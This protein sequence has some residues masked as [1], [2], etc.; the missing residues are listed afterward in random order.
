MGGDRHSRDKLKDSAPPGAWQACADF[1]ELW[2][3]PSFD[4]TYDSLPLDAFEPAVRRVLGRAP[5]AADPDNLK[6][7]LVTGAPPA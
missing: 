6:R 3:A 2:D 5:Y 1:C 4:D 7:A